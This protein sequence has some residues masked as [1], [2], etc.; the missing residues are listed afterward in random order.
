MDDAPEAPAEE[1]ELPIEFEKKLSDLINE[2]SLEGGSDT[3]DFI[4]A[5]YMNDCLQAYNN[6][7]KRKANWMTL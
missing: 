3:P 1:Q 2:Y 5:G 6:A 7:A 4:L